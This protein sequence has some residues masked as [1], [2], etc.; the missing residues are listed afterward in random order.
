MI[1]NIVDNVVYINNLS[2]YF[3]FF[4]FFIVILSV[5]TERIVLLVFL[6]GYNERILYW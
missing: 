4:Y 1:F 6:D 3:L 5:Y 2:S